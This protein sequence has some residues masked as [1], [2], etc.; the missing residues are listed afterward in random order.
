MSRAS[1]LLYYTFENQSQNGQIFK[2][3]SFSTSSHIGHSTAVLDAL[4][5]PLIKGKLLMWRF[6][7]SGLRVGGFKS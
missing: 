7:I 3:F 6:M 1:K 2:S 5:F 4:K